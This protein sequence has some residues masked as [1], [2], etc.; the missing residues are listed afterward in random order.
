MTR[1]VLAQHWHL[2][3]FIV[4]STS[5]HFV[6]TVNQQYLHCL[7]YITNTILKSLIYP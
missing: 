4:C 3:M 6:F 2:P 5:N 1:H 7:N